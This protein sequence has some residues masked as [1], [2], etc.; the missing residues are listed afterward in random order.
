[1]RIGRRSLGH[2]HATEVGNAVH[3]AVVTLLGGLQGVVGE[4]DRATVMGR[5][6]EETDGHGRISLL[7]AVVLTLEELLECDKVAER[8]AHL[9]AVDGDHV[10]VHPVVNHLVALRCHGLRNL[11]FV[12]GENQVHATSV[13]VEVGAQ[14]L[15][16]HGGALTVPSREAVAPW[17]GPSHDVLGLRLLPKGEVGLVVLLRRAGQVAALVDDVLEV[18]A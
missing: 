2:L 13:D 8:L 16:A 5:E 11:T 15:A 6:D 18:A 12:V 3:Q 14:V 9:L 1:M 4:V 10:V 17:R 7:Q